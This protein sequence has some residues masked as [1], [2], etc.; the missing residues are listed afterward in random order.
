[1]ND[2]MTNTF[3]DCFEFHGMEL[4]EVNI[5]DDRREQDAAELVANSDIIL[6]GGGHVPTQSAFFNRIGLRVLLRE[7]E[8]VVIGISAGSMNCANIVYAQPECPGESL[9]PYYR[10]FMPGLGLADVMILPHYQKVKNYRL[11]G[12]RL[13]EDI[14]YGDSFG[15]EF[16]AMPDGSYV[17]VEDGSARL[18]G[19]GYRVA[20]GKIK[21]I[22]NEE[23]TIE[24]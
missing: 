12:K 16:I 5:L 3:A 11:D 9:D 8:G 18:F 13:Y 7:F 4:S 22:C 6:L 10:R 17:L 14:T 24:L 1:M 19:E 15:R 2:E 20:E 21:R 23:E